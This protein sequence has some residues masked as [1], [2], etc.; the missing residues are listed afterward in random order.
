M[1]QGMCVGRDKSHTDN[2]LSPL[3]PL[4]RL[5]LFSDIEHPK[6][7]LSLQATLDTGEI[8]FKELQMPIE[9]SC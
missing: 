5:H 6:E 3:K 7:E 2:V 4:D 9:L 1:Q 8:Y